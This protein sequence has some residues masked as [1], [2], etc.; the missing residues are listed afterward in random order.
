VRTITT[1]GRTLALS[2]GGDPSGFPVVVQHGTP[3]SGL[4]D[5]QHDALARD[6]GVRLIGLDRAG[7]RGSS[8]NV[9]RNVAAAA[10]DVNA[11]ADELSLERYATWG[12]SGGGPHAL[13][14]A[15]LCDDRLVAVASLAAVAPYGVDGLDW[16]DGMGEENHVEFDKALS[17]EQ[18]LRPYL[19]EQREELLG[20]KS[21]ELLAVMETLLGPEDRAVLSGPYAEFMLA[22]QQ[23]G[24]EPGP[25]GW[26]D[27]DVA[28]TLPWGFELDAI[29]R[30][31]VL[32]H[33][34]DDRFVPVSHGHWLAARIPGVEA[35]ITETDGHLTLLT[36]RMREVNDWLL[37]HR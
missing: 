26:I 12:V 31:V 23:Q 4:L 11:I 9:D 33:G 6:Q 1:A 8:R 10:A 29:N 17:G 13:A 16:L 21:E 7:Y 2:E 14:C 24:V 3:G 34:A 28:F 32:L 30:P 15:A 5:P 27:D 18:E 19:D 22:W 35:R 36:R 25:D 20:A 37:A